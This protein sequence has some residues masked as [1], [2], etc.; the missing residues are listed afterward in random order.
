MP[1]KAKTG[2]FS[3]AIYVLFDHFFYKGPH[4][5]FVP[6]PLTLGIKMSTLDLV[7]PLNL[8][9]ATPLLMVKPEINRPFA[10]R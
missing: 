3:G 4:F 1:Y 2:G 9:H 6:P 5:P 10:T 8:G 7:S